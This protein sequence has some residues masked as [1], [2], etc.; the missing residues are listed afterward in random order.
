MFCVSTVSFEVLVNG[1][2]SDQFKPSRG[3]RQRDPLSSYLF[4]IGQEVMSKLIEKEFELKT[5]VEL[6]LVSMHHLSPM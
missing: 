5:L 4:I 3:L 2:K 1:G 6:K